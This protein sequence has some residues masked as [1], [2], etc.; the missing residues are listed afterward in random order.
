MA[1]G[2]KSVYSE[3]VERAIM[4][5][6]PIGGDCA[7]SIA[8]F[9]KD[10]FLPRLLKFGLQDMSIEDFVKLKKS[11]LPFKYMIFTLEFN[12]K[13]WREEGEE[14]TNYLKWIIEQFHVNDVGGIGDHVAFDV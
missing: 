1:T 14:M 3:K 5:Q 7:N 10:Y 11:Q 12:A 2:K 8:L 9:K 4:Q 6:L 13:T